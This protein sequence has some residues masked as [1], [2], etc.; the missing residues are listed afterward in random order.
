MLYVMYMPALVGLSL[1]TVEVSRSHSDAPHS[2]GLRTSARLIAEASPLQHKTLVI[3]IH[4]PG[5]IRT[6]NP[7][8]RGTADP[9]LR[10][11]RPMESA[12]LKIKTLCICQIYYF[13]LDRNKTFCFVLCISLRFG[14]RKVLLTT[15]CPDSFNYNI[16]SCVNADI[17]CN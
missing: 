7:S 2:V 13:T 16:L 14:D 5:G 8:K 17:F 15:E 6:P 9:C 12:S 4:D 11:A 1:L 3:D 10:T